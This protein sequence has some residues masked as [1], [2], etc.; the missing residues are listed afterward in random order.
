MFKNMIKKVMPVLLAATLLV[1]GITP[2]TVNAASNVR[3]LD[4]TVAKV[5]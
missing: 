1:T 3:T 4:S 5:K 2:A